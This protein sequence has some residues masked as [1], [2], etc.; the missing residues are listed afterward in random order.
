[1]CLHS[2]R[3][4]GWRGAGACCLQGSL[5]GHLS[6]CPAPCRARR[7]CVCRLPRHGGGPSPRRQQRPTV[8]P[9]SAPQRISVQSPA[10]PWLMPA[11]VFRPCPTTHEI[12]SRKGSSA[13]RAS[14]ACSGQRGWVTSGE[15]RSVSVLPPDRDPSLTLQARPQ[16]V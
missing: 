2:P 6:F 9:V 7:C 10:G 12:P 1:M 4:Q 8:L 15:S 13:R 14:A 16:S 5:R 11:G 3:G